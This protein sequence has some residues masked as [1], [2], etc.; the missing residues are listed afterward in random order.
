MSITTQEI[1]RSQWWQFFD[2]LGRL[3]DGWAIGIEVMNRDIGDQPASEGLILQA[4][5]FETEGSDAG[6]IL[7]DIGD[8]EAVDLVHR[9]HEP[10]RVLAADLQP[11]TETDVQIESAEGTTIIHLRRR[12][13]IPQPSR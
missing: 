1:P 5:S 13:E 6:D 4:A 7:F 9:I 11:G 3:Y 12:P 8:D 10:R 2:D